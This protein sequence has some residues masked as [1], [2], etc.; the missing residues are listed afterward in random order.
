MITSVNIQPFY[1]SSLYNPVI[2]TVASN[3]SS[4]AGF[5]Y[6]FDF[7]VDDVKV[8]TVKQPPNPNGYGTID[9][10]RII[11]NHIT[12][13]DFD[14]DFEQKTGLGLQTGEE[15]TKRFGI[16]I[17][18]EYLV[19]S[20]YVTY[21]GLT[22][23]IPDAPAYDP[24]AATFYPI[25]MVGALEPIEFKSNL[26][27]NRGSAY[28]Q[29]M[30]S[31]QDREAMSRWPYA[32]AQSVYTYD[33]H[34]LTFMSNMLSQT[35]GLE[36]QRYIYGFVFDFYNSSDV[37]ITNHTVW[38]EAAQGGGP[39]IDHNTDYDTGTLP[40]S[41][42][43]VISLG[44]GP[45]NNAYG[46]TL[47]NG[48][49]YYKVTGYLPALGA[50]GAVTGNI[51]SA[52]TRTYRFNVNDCDDKA[53]FKRI[54]LTWL[55]DVGGWDSFNFVKANTEDYEKSVQEYYV[56]PQD[57]SGVWSYDPYSGGSMPYSNT[58][59][60][61][62]TASTDWITEEESVFLKGLFKSSRVFAY[63]TDSTTELARPV[64]VTDTTYSVNTYARNKMYQYILKIADA[65]KFNSQS[66]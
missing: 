13:R 35:T 7:Y 41:K 64:T 24:N 33:K 32:S 19:G 3:K 39:W 31:L 18:E 2:W 52:A 40:E 38:N 25:G 47:P 61:S 30:Y 27:T 28:P 48:T 12:L 17:G 26:V 54:R 63:L 5:K 22:N 62:R 8:S 51:G 53:G 60:I 29:A 44:V 11:R 50:T 46:P 15:L 4:E 57:Y 49:S 43:G 58:V 66:L 34:V 14:I 37:R 59:G 21:D 16:R 20:N 45:A 10:S 1:W 56:T 65:H 6:V 55:N 23:T 42:Y 9:G 36:Q